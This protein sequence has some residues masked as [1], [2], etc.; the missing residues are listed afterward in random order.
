MNSIQWPQLWVKSSRRIH[1]SDEDDSQKK[2]SKIQQFSSFHPLILPFLI[3]SFARL[4]ITKHVSFRLLPRTLYS[5]KLNSIPL[6]IIKVLFHVNWVVVDTQKITTWMHEQKEF[7]SSLLHSCIQSPHGVSEF[8][9]NNFLTF[10][11][12]FLT[13]TRRTKFRNATTFSIKQFHIIPR[14]WNAQ[15]A[16]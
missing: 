13:H 11:L 8:N 1:K 14:T 12:L 9:G 16:R 2:S 15:V 6:I 4:S 5:L 3:K 7:D 10:Q